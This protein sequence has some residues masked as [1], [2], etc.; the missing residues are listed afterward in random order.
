MK[1]WPCND[2]E[3]GSPADIDGWYEKGSCE[4]RKICG[5]WGRRD[6]WVYGFCNSWNREP[7]TGI[8]TEPGITTD[9]MKYDI[10]QDCDKC[11]SLWVRE[12]CR[13]V[14]AYREVSYGSFVD[15][16]ERQVWNVLGD[17]F[18]GWG[19]WWQLW[20]WKNTFQLT[21]TSKDW[22]FVPNQWLL[23]PNAHRPKRYLVYWGR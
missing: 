14:Q 4:A 7:E 23:L 8:G 21:E 16:E 3:F 2:Q 15:V 5:Y 12:H 22:W 10:H 19:G 17:T 11:G 9:A 13:E 18:A 6:S 20:D 1:L